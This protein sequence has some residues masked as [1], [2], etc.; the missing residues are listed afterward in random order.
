M[1]HILVVEDDP[2]LSDGLIPRLRQSGYA[3]D[4]VAS[5]DRADDALSTGI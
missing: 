2:V 3:V 4:C 1:T 5:G